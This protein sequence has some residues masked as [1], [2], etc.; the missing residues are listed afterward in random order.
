[1]RTTAT[2][3][4]ALMAEAARL[5]GETEPAALIRLAVET[6]IRTEAA[7]RLAALG[8]TDRTATAA[9]RRRDPA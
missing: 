7:R 2:I 4:D 8:G 6:L 5:T 9:P 3:D 1:L